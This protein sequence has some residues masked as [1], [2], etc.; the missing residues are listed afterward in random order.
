M[1]AQR[2]SAPFTFEAEVLNAP[3]AADLQPGQ[4]LLRPLTIGICGSDLPYFKGLELPHRTVRDGQSIAR[5]GAPLHEVVGEVIAS[6]DN[7]LEP[8]AVVVGWASQADALAELIVA[9]GEGLFPYEARR[10][11]EQAVMLQPLACA[12]YALSRLEGIRGADV[13]VIGQGPIG[14][15]FSH[16]LK[17]MGAR[18]VTGVDRIDRSGIAGVFGVDEAVHAS[19]RE[20][21]AGITDADRPTLVV[22]A[23]GHQPDTLSDAV[24]AL[25]ME[26]HVYCFGVP[27]D[28]TYPFP[29]RSFLRKNA[30]LSAG[31][32]LKPHR[33][34][35]LAQAQ[36][37][38]NAHPVL[39]ERYVSHV[40]APSEANGA[41]RRAITPAPDQLKVAMTVP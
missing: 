20:W 41:F 10:P 3:T 12:I 11:P 1:W 16:V 39:A 19:S 31:V 2:L 28:E 26:G 4:V 15:L 24:E 33:R 36:E 13:A 14:V 30:Q 27:D 35:A 38:L 21:A 9:D 18:H 32:T 8:G 34:Q 5:P 6:R 23:V 22:E 25:A 17:S 7:A 37:H 29:M 40:Y